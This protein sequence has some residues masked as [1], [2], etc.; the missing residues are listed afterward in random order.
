MVINLL[1]QVTISTQ[2]R[3]K[4]QL[5]FKA[6][7]YDMSSMVLLDFRLSRGCGLDF[8]RHFLTIKLT[9]ADILCTGPVTWSIAKATNS[10]P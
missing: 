4:M 1:F 9:L 10:V 8:K 7:V 3:R 2:D 6:T 5:V